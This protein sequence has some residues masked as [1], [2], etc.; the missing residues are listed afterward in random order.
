MNESDAPLEINEEGDWVDQD[1][2][3]LESGRIPGP[4]GTSTVPPAGDQ[5]IPVPRRRW[6]VPSPERIAWQQKLDRLYASRERHEEKIESLMTKL[7]TVAATLRKWRRGRR[8][9]IR[10]LAALAKAEPQ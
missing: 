3:T 4:D 5:A 2:G 8:L 6:P 7:L 9:L 10:R 1:L